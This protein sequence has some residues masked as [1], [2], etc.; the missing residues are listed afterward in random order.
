M[1]DKKATGVMSYLGMY[2]KYRDKSLTMT[3]QL[4]N[5]KNKFENWPKD[6]IEVTFVALKKKPKAT[7]RSDYRTVN[8]IKHTVNSAAGILKKD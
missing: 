1:K 6:L 7:K 5:N 4:I 3:T 2:S 8:F